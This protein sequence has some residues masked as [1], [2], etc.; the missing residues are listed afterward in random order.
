MPVD[1]APAPFNAYYD[2]PGR[3]DTP[4]SLLETASES[5][6]AK[7][8]PMM[9]INAEKEL[10]EPFES[11]KEI[12]RLLKERGVSDVTE[13]TSIGHNHVSAIFALLSGEGEE[14][15]HEVVRWIKAH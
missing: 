13:Y 3:K 7:L 2:I 1:P 10:D 8:P 15:G 6:V 11:S 5:S 14:W 9:I 4:Y 12:V